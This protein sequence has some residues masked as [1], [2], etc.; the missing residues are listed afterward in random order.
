V[1]RSSPRRELYGRTGSIAH[2]E[3][4]SSTAAA[5][6]L[7]NE[8]DSARDFGI[9]F[10]GSPPVLR[11][12]QRPIHK[13]WR[14]RRWDGG[15]FI[16]GRHPWQRREEWRRRQLGHRRRTDNG[17]SYRYGRQ[18]GRRRRTDNRWALRFGWELGRRI[19]RHTRRRLDRRWRRRR[20][21]CRWWQRWRRFRDR[22]ELVGRRRHGF[23]WLRQG[24]HAT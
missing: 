24:H 8:E 12:K 6:R 2:R 17:W 21:L 4:M 10:R 7:T 14:G 13:Q 15:N 22:R 19:R 1:S 5:R 11:G 16:H 18:L 9:W 3:Q 23:P 20:Q